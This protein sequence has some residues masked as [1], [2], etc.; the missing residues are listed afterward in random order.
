MDYTVHGYSGEC[1]FAS[2]DDWGNAA[3]AHSYAFGGAARRGDLTWRPPRVCLCWEAALPRAVLN[4]ER[5]SVPEL[6]WPTRIHPPRARLSFAA[7]RLDACARERAAD[8]AGAERDARPP[9][10]RTVHRARQSAFHIGRAGAAKTS[11]QEGF[12]H[13]LWRMYRGSDLAAPACAHRHHWVFS[14]RSDRGRSARRR[15]PTKWGAF[16]WT[17]ARGFQR[18]FASIPQGTFNRSGIRPRAIAEILRS[19]DKQILDAAVAGQSQRALVGVGGPRP[20]RGP[21]EYRTAFSVGLADGAGGRHRARRA[22]MPRSVRLTHR[23][24]A[25]PRAGDAQLSCSTRARLARRPR[26]RLSA[27]ADARSG[28]RRSLRR[29]QECQ[30]RRQHRCYFAPRTA[31]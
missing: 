21:K 25:A 23:R 2:F 6:R 20:G 8:C 29:K 19:I 16:F 12:S 30:T 1:R 5:F 24:A 27:F 28:S 11:A 13:Q 17:A 18:R 15:V 31:S 7:R 14:E 10:Q 4:D 22:A 3:D 9:P 26:L